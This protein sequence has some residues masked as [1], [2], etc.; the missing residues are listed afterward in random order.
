M[1]DILMKNHLKGTRLKLWQLGFDLYVSRYSFWFMIIIISCLSFFYNYQEILFF[2]PQSIHQWRQCYG[3]SFA[4]NYYQDNNPFFQPALNF[5]GGDGT[6]KTA[7]EFPLLYYL[8][9]KLWKIFGYHEYI[10]RLVDLLIFFIG[11]IAL[12]KTLEDILKDSFHA[13]TIS[14]LLFASP[15]LVYYANNFIPN[16]PSL[17]LVLIAWYF[18]WLFFKTQKSLFLWISVTFFALA[19]L[20][21]VTAIISLIALVTILLIEAVGI[22][23]FRKGGRLFQQ[24]LIQWIPFVLAFVLIFSWYM[25]ANYYNRHHNADLLAVGI[26]PIWDLTRDQIPEHLRGIKDQVKWSY[27]HQS[28]YWVLLVI[29]TFIIIF[30]K[31]ANKFLLF[32]TV[33]IFIGMIS[34]FILFFRM[35]FQH[36]Y[37]LIDLYIFIPVVFLTIIYIFKN[38]YPVFYR[39]LILRTFFIILLILNANFTKARINERYS[40]MKNDNYL[41]NIQ[42]FEKITPYLRSIG[43]GADDKVLCLPDPSP[44]ITLYFMNQKGWTDYGVGMDSA[45]IQEKI[46]QGAEYLF[47]YVD[48]IYN[49]PNLKPYITNKIGDYNGIGIFSLS[50]FH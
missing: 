1:I 30:L 15:V 13:I 16:T 45:R 20:I 39:S 32:L 50:E 42:R 41:L 47:V 4:L 27:F 2:R 28:M 49:N 3:L 31:K 9:A 34:Y 19:G 35:L 10:F 36:D 12:M 17:G 46:R 40:I 5:I 14:L 23:K 48:S 18:F 11:L 38:Y 25:Y 7:G 22:T 21:K 24:P 33:L 26:L 44:V 29:C 8:V 6:G 37:Y 43:I